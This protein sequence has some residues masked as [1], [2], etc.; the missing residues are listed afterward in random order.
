[1]TAISICP[2]K[3]CHSCH[4]EAENEATKGPGMS[5]SG[6]Q[7]LL[8]TKP[9]LRISA[10]AATRAW[11]TLV[12]GRD[13]GDISTRLISTPVDRPIDNVKEEEEEEEEHTSYDVWGV[14]G[15]VHQGLHE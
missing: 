11:R 13:S 6:E 12:A 15:T 14:S 5:L 3:I 7:Y 4:K 8:R 9:A 2:F 1:M 10:A